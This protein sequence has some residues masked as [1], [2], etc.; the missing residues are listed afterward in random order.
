MKAN[1]LV[2]ALNWRYAVKK[3]D[4]T[5][6]INDQ[7][8]EALLESLRLSPS[9]FGLQFWEFVVV[10]NDELREKLVAHSWNQAQVKDASH[11]IVLCAKT[12]ANI[13]HVNA[14]A[15]NMAKLRGQT[16][17][18]ME[19]FLKYAGGFVERLSPE[20]ADAWMKNQ[21]YIALGF[22]LSA[23]SVLKIDATPM[24]GFIPEKVDA[25]LGL[26]AKGLKSIL[27]CPVGYRSDE[28]KY[29]NMAKARFPKDQV[30]RV[31]K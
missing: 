21:V 7:E 27:L 8:F 30:I 2:E 3:F 29:A 26:H 28:D 20:K 6:K 11:L 12:K 14:H 18:D 10:E 15:E 13:E 5:K 1:E 19:G 31:I 24:E 22:L 16:M 9:S 4:P 25:E 23:C 17:E